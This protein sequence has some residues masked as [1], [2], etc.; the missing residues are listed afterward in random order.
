MLKDSGVLEISLNLEP[1][2]SEFQFWYCYHRL[3]CERC[4]PRVVQYA[5][6]TT[7]C[8]GAA[9]CPCLEYEKCGGCLKDLLEKLNELMFA[10]CVAWGLHTEELKNKDNT[11]I[12]LSKVTKLIKEELRFWSDIKPKSDRQQSNS[13]YYVLFKVHNKGRREMEEPGSLYQCW[14]IYST[15]LVQG[16]IGAK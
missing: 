8:G 14:M 15:F 6:F 16:T 12:K 13:F 10:K 1:A 7:L 9:N 2:K 4:H 5:T 3:W 11:G